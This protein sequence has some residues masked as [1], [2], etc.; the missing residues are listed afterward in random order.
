M[1]IVHHYVVLLNIFKIHVFSLDENDV[2]ILALNY[3]YMPT[4][5][6]AYTEIC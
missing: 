3:H 4:L 5:Y 6:V 1:E 2:N